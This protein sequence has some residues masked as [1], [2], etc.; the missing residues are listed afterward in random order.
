MVGRR[1]QLKWTALLRISRSVAAMHHHPGTAIRDRVNRL[2]GF[3]KR[4]SAG[5]RGAARMQQF[6]DSA[7]VCLESLKSVDL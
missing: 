7:G 3:W 5:L 4:K 1:P 2:F 6:Y